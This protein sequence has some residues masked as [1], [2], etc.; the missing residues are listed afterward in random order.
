[1]DNNPNI[2]NQNPNL[3]SEKTLPQ[4]NIQ[5]NPQYL[6]NSQPVINQSVQT[7]IPNTNQNPTRLGP[8]TE[9]IKT[10]PPQSQS[11]NI[12]SVEE[13]KTKKPF[14]KIILIP[15]ILVIISAIGYLLLTL[16][17]K[18]R[19]QK[20]ET[21]P[22][23]QTGSDLTLE[24]SQQSTN[25]VT[26]APPGTTEFSKK[27]YRQTKSTIEEAQA[28]QKKIA[29]DFGNIV[30]PENMN[31][32]HKEVYKGIEI[33]WTDQQP[34]S[35]ETLSW[36]KSAI[37]I[38]PEYFYKEHP[39]EA[40]ISA[41][42]K[43]LDLITDPDLAGAAAYA[44]G[45]NIFLSSEFAQGVSRLHRVD[46]P[47]L[48]ET[49]FHEWVHIVQHYEVLQTFSDEY[50]SIPGNL[51]VVFG[52]SPFTKEYAKQAG[53]KFQYDEYADSTYAILENDSESQKITEYGKTKYIEDMAESGSLFMLC[54]T[55]Q[56]SET[57]I[58][59]WEKTTNTNRQNYCPSLI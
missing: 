55:D 28:L 13:E 43:E 29:K 21:Y 44:S 40:I 18:N 57:R 2:T 14:N 53:W 23:I 45:L 47:T 11:P 58:T 36:I 49:M 35:T 30:I 5:S 24:E 10:Q 15:I 22:Q 8:E 42:Y 52:L 27:N 56:L 32:P 59:W 7:P 4:E 26:L 25:G 31:F 6:D 17:L 48:I 1:M 54:K 12:Q 34:I 16:F 33:K 50:L 19:N 46:K 51:L 39:V 41:D 37:D 9:T 3:P 38:L 20:T